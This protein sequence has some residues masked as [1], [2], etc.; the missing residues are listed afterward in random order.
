[1]ENKHILSRNGPLTEQERKSWLVLEAI[2]KSGPLTKTEIS[3]ITGLNIVTVSN[4]VNNYISC[5]LVL[6]RGFNS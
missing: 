4:Y 2:R 1:M 6:A 5:G 3:R